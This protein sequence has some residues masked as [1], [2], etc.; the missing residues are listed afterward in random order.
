M[1]PQ[2]KWVR[3]PLISFEEID[4]A[5]VTFHR[6]GLSNEVHGKAEV[7]VEQ[8]PENPNL[9]AICVRIVRRPPIYFDQL[10]VA[11]L[12]RLGNG[13]FAYRST[14]CGVFDESHAGSDG[15]GR[16]SARRMD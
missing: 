9:A 7:F 5:E 4:G 12:E 10:D 11:F 13:C 6:I 16:S 8:H 15:E 3:S 2:K 14:T 1:S